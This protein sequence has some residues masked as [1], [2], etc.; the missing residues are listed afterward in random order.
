MK[1]NFSREILECF[2]SQYPDKWRDYNRLLVN[3]NANKILAILELSKI[4]DDF[5]LK[6]DFLIKLIDKLVEEDHN[7]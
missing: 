4:Y 3:Y 7:D 6:M 5:I 2:A 1:T